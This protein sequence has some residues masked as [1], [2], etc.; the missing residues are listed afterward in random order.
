MSITHD[1]LSADWTSGDGFYEARIWYS[2]RDSER[3]YW[4]WA[5]FWP[6]GEAHCDGGERISMPG[7]T[8]EPLDVLST[9]ASFLTAW[10][11][12]RQFGSPSSENW[13]LFTEDCLEFEP[14]IDEF[15]L[16]GYDRDGMDN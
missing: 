15:G 8:P 1:D 14:A 10:Q 12:S 2:G 9:L 16:W 6:G 11:E 13:D 5:L 4:S 7:D 3:G